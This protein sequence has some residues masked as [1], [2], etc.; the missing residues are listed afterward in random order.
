MPTQLLIHHSLCP[1]CH[2]SCPRQA[3]TAKAQTLDPEEL[4]VLQRFYDQV[5]ALVEAQRMSDPLSLMI[6]HKVCQY[7]DFD[8]ASS[9]DTG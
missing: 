9:S 4:R 1:W 2:S 7:T 3:R 5:C 8:L 6:I